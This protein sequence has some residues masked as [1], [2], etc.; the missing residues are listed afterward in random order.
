MTRRP[1]SAH[2]AE[3]ASA[4]ANKDSGA[5][6]SKGFIAFIDALGIKGIGGRKDPRAVVDGWKDLVNYFDSEAKGAGIQVRA[7]SDTLI[8]IAEADD[9]ETADAPIPAL[10]E[11]TA[12]L[13]LDALDK[14]FLL[15]GAISKG[16]FYQGNSMIIG[17]AVD[18][19]AEWFEAAEWMG[20]MLTPQASFFVDRLQLSGQVEG[21]R[22]L[23]KYPVPCRGCASCES[24]VVSW[25]TLELWR[26]VA[27]SGRGRNESVRASRL[28][29]VE[30]YS[31]WPIG[32]VDVAKFHNT[33]KFLSSYHD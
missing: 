2:G 12:G 30:A 8:A 7:F 6:E 4:Q 9:L 29:L 23:V 33:L 31:K 25:P 17:P 19:A 27:P 15:R 16:V 3:D 10:V 28:R 21:I 22:K 11:V 20:I 13:F 18:D 32:Q 26:G 24:W 5:R 1:G 14:G